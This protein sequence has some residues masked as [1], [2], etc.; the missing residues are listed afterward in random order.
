MT[1]TYF[2]EDERDARPRSHVVNKRFERACGEARSHVDY[3][4]STLGIRVPRPSMPSIARRGRLASSAA[5]ARWARL[6][7]R[8]LMFGEI[9]M[10]GHVRYPDWLV[11]VLLALALAGCG[12]E[13]GL[14][15]SCDDAAEAMSVGLSDELRTDTLADQ[16]QHIAKEGDAETRSVFN[17]YIKELR[18]LAEQGKVDHSY[19]YPI[20]DRLASRCGLPVD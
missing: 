10:R 5:S 7:V 11:P 3:Q 14:S 13:D 9:L 16:L 15:Q 8:S 20:T 12:A 17:P 19:V 2:V 18:A 1:R 6:F 4:T